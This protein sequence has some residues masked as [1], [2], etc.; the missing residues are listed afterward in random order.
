M[1]PGQTAPVVASADGG[2]G[3]PQ[4]VH[5][6][7]M[8]A[9]T[10]LALGLCVLMSLPFLSAMAW[11][12]ALVILVLPFQGLMERRFKRVGLATTLTVL[13][14]AIT[15][16]AP[17]LM[18]TSS[19]V[20]EAAVTASALQAQL[21]SGRLRELL[22]Q[23][24]ALTPWVAWGEANFDLGGV[25]GATSSKVTG[26]AADFVRGSMRQAVM[27][28]LTFYLLFYFLRDRHLALRSIRALS[29]LSFT[30]MSTLYQRVG[31]ALYATIYGTF[32]VAAVQGLL[33]GLMF[34]W[35]GLPAPLLWGV[36]MGLLAIIPVLGAFV[37]W[38]PAALFLL[39]TGEPG[40][41]LILA[42]WGTVI[43]GGID[44][45]MY[46]MLV[47]NRMHLHTV[48]VFISVVGGLFVFGAAG[49]I[50]GP[51][52]LTITSVLLE[53]WRHPAGE[54]PAAVANG[55]ALAR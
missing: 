8:L 49:L 5:T 51:M 34:W 42:I 28:L 47:G 2:W 15:V 14:T 6:L 12:L 35:L 7:A 55:E 50:L 29:P 33:G 52:V 38:V 26:L 11:A 43:V 39:A 54:A 44:N 45:L 53:I 31:D 21:E 3:S 19:I 46:P 30:Q 27:L 22:L 1:E 9:L 40:K 48:L 18:I 4:H 20:G 10:L 41:A 36:V 24:P 32:A 16:V 37:V 23:Y 25:I 17:V 13:A